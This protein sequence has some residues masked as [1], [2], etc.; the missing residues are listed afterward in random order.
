MKKIITGIVLLFASVAG[1]GQQEN[2]GVFGSPVIPG[3]RGVFI[4]A[5][6]AAHRTQK[7]SVGKS[8]ILFKEEKRGAGFKKLAVINFPATAAELEK[9]LGAELLQNIL[10][11]RKL[12]SVQDLY[13][14]LERGR[15][16]TLGIF[17][18][19]APVQEAL[20]MLYIDQ[21]V[22]T[23]DPAISYRLSAVYNGYEQVQYQINLAGIQYEAM[24]VFKQYRATINDSSALV[25]WYATRLKA[26]YATVFANAGTGSENKFNAGAQQYIYVKKDTLF[27]TYSTRTAPGTKLLAY[28]QP[29]DLAG[30]RGKASDT[31]HLLALGFKDRIGIQ[32]LRAADTLGSVVLQWDSLPAK[33]W[34]SGIEVLKSRFATTDFTVID[35]LP[36]TAVQY[37]DHKTISGNLYY[38]Q[39][40]PL[41][42]DLP[43]KGRITPAVVNV[44]TKS[45]L[46][47]IPAPQ[48]L[49]LGLNDKA[50]IKLNWLP[51]AELN[52]FGYYILR[53]TSA[54][55]LQVISSAIRDTVFI[56]SLKALNSGI[57]YL[58]A[59]AAMDMDMHWSDTSAPVAMQSPL[60]NLATAPGG[61]QARASAQ[62]VRLKW[63]DVSIADASVT[64]YMVYRRKK[65]EQYFTQLTTRPVAGNYFTD[66]SALPAGDYEYGCSSVDV[67]NHVSVL[68][69]VASVH[70][71]ADNNGPLALYPPAGFL[72]RNGKD[73]IEIMLPAVISLSSEKTYGQ[74]T[75]KYNLY[76]RQV[77]EKNFKKIGEIAPGTLSYTD[78]KVVKDQLYAYTVSVQKEKE[79]SG[80]SGEKSI[81]RK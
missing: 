50:T 73:G 24:P 59:I 13:S 54:V 28:L 8:Y 19:S 78:R 61:I 31:V 9:R 45:T 76:R 80:R 60:A 41:L 66:S 16:D 47:R 2:K 5:T 23:A 57:T 79:E 29:E 7:P 11:Q 6:D 46:H 32:H 74:K 40:R 35:T 14:Q 27:V 4:Y 3:P 77:T 56:D 52:I 37:R 36:I 18:L 17:A 62:G 10:R 26:A 43:Q 1:M 55:N 81:R 15:F 39:L 58:Y 20:G 68:S 22:T 12:H 33:A 69:P 34:C 75:V 38:Y 48:G 42:F 25:T 49:Q 30:N 51:N 67:W 53:G 44:R 70:L 65:G 21:T 63:N 71:G 64:G 72:L